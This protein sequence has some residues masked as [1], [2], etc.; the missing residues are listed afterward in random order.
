MLW[1]ARSESHPMLST[2]AREGHGTLVA[3]E[4]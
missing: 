2:D 1:R 3:R 4:A